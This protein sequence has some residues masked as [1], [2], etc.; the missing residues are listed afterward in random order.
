LNFRKAA[1]G[2]KFWV[3][4]NELRLTLKLCW[5]PQ[6]I[7]VQEGDPGCSR[8]AN[9]QIP[10]LRYPVCHLIWMPVHACLVSLTGSPLGGDFVRVVL[11]TI[12]YDNALPGIEGLLRNTV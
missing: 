4:V 2:A 6:I 5:L 7:L 10:G 1:D 9:S 11:R 8:F 12:V 3:V